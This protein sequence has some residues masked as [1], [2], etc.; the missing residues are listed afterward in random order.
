VVEV[1]AAIL[2]AA[3][4][5]AE[6]DDGGVRKRRCGGWRWPEGPAVAAEIS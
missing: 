5:V 1:C 2:A 4:E 3:Q 6:D